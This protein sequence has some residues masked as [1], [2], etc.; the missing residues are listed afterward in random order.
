MRQQSELFTPNDPPSDS[1]PTDSF[2][3]CN[4]EL[5]R[6]VST[7]LE[8]CY[9]GCEFLA[10]SWYWALFNNAVFVRTKFT[11]CIFDGCSFAGCTFVECE[12]SGCTFGLDSFGKPCSFEESKW[13]GCSQSACKGIEDVF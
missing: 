10:C 1:W 7:P 2:H 13:Y 9:L 6:D 5:L 12:F 4:F 3:Y 8:G 11:N